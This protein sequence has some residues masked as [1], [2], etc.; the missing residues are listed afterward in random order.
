MGVLRV[1]KYL[2]DFIWTLTRE[3]ENKFLTQFEPKST[4]WNLHAHIA[5]T[6]GRY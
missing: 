5:K 6:G 4:D 3:N 2:Y 1:H